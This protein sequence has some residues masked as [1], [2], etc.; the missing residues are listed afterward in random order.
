M[1]VLESQSAEEAMSLLDQVGDEVCLLITG[2]KLAGSM[3][4]LTL[5]RQVKNR[6]PDMDV[7]ITSGYSPPEQLPGHAKF[8]P[9]PWRAL[10]V[11]Q[12]AGRA[13]K[14]Q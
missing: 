10:D 5:A 8:M 3:S 9:K 1:E 6:F 14:L 13:I 7:V 2:V 12:E 11:I 4:G